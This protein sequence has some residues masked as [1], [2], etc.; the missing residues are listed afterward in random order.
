MPTGRDLIFRQGYFGEPDAFEALAV[1]LQDIFSIDIR[2]MQW[3][4]GV[5]P[6]CMPFG[7]FDAEGRCVANFSVFSMPLAVNGRTMRVAAYQSGAVSP[8]YRGRGLYR[9]LMQRAFTYARQTG[10]EADILLTGKP[11]LYVPYGLRSVRMF[12][13]RGA[14]PRSSADGSACQTLSLERPAD[15]QR[16]SAI[17]D[18]RQPVSGRFAVTGLKALF[19]LNA[20]WQRDEIKL[21]YLSRQKAI[22]AWRQEAEKLI[23]FD[24]VSAEIPPLGEICAALGAGCS[25]VETR[26]S[27]DRFQWAEAEAIADPHVYLMASTSLA[28]QLERSPVGFTPLAE[29]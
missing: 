24:V 21:S 3:L 13:F 22:V 12:G 9:D 4:G 18:I 8:A 20:W 6:T 2:P 29:F 17:L 27:P 25:C 19:L 16:V 14:M 15:L 7:Y 28:E 1:L 5:D 26:F 23:V 10:H 11:Q